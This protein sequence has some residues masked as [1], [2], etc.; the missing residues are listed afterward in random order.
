MGEQL[1]FRMQLTKKRL[2]D[3][4]LKNKIRI[5]LF[6]V[7]VAAVLIIGI[8][9]YRTAERELIRNSEDAV[10][11]LQVQG[12]KSLDDRINAFEDATF[13][14]LQASNIEKLL[15]YSSDEAEKRRII[16]EG[17]PTVVTQ[18]SVLMNYTSFALLQPLSG[19]TYS[20][21]RGNEKKLGAAQEKDL[22]ETLDEKVDLHHIKRWINHDGQ[23]YFVRQVVNTD[24]REEGILCFAV[25]Q[26]F[27]TIIGEGIPYLSDEKMMIHSLQGEELYGGDDPLQSRIFDALDIGGMKRYGDFCSERLDMDRDTF[28]VTAI[29]TP[30]NGWTLISYFRHS[31]ILKGIRT[32]VRAI[33]WIILAVTAAVLAVTALISH[34]ITRNVT[35]IEEG[36]KHY[37][38]GDFSYRI[39]PVSYD[40]VGLLGLQLNYMALRLDELIR[41]LRLREEEKKRLEIETLQAQ[42]NPHFLYNTLGSLKWAAF[43]N[44]QKELAASLDALIQLLRFTIKKADG[45]VTVE[46]ELSYIKNYIAIEHMRYGEGFLVEYEVDEAVR[47]TEIPGFILQPLV[48]NSIIHGLDQTRPDGRIV[49]RARQENS[50]LMIEVEDNGLGIPAEKLEHI[51]EPETEHKSRGLNSIGMKIV[52]R[53]LS[54][55]YGEKYHTD[56]QSEEG[57][58][59]R[60]RLNIPCGKEGAA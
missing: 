39:R 27:F 7:S 25:D 60:I 3:I 52:D 21:Y 55:I 35:I 54:E 12:G 5:C 40:E 31:E 14:I 44:G 58:G 17:L 15:G 24:L 20:Y 29:R 34:T 1:G 19:V 2:R 37:E 45:M 56:I 18:H 43:R 13:Q 59:T 51:L 8:Y 10:L 16:N 30:L 23:V 22:L 50:F 6:I 48:E 41:T 26:S 33:N 57:K 11:N 32:I 46:E 28:S 4:S 38:E 9:S 53:R 36:T 42:I 47:N 49:I